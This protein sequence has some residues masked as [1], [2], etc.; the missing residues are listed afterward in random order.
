MLY[1]PLVSK[2]VYNVYRGEVDKDIWYLHILIL[3]G[4]RALVYQL[5]SSYTCMLFLNRACRINQLGIEFNQID[6]E[7]HW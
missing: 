5:W 2:V 3:F 6:A 4:L 7:W 1:G